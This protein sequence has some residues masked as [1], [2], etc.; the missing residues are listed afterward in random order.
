MKEPTMPV[1][2]YRHTI[3]ID[4]NPFFFNNMEEFIDDIWC[5]LKGNNITPDKFSLEDMTII[6]DDL[7]EETDGRFKIEVYKYE[8][9]YQKKLKNYRQDYS[10]YCKW[11]KEHAEEI[12]KIE[13]NKKKEIL[14]KNIEVKEKEIIN[15][16]EQLKEQ[17]K[18]LK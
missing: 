2:E 16:K 14:L 8:K 6:C 5:E 3:R 7:S 12:E 15:L 9:E 1:R 10:N 17:F 18:K 4:V 13:Y 11:K